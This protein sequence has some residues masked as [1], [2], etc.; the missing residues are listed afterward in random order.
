[1]P[2]R[3]MS[4]QLLW[5]KTASTTSSGLAAPDR[6]IAPR[7]RRTGRRGL[8]GIEPSSANFS[9]MGWDGLVGTGMAV[10]ADMGHAIQVCARRWHALV[11]GILLNEPLRGSKVAAGC[12][13]PVGSIAIARRRARGIRSC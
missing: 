9:A 8:L 12:V 10:R 3:H 2:L 6:S 7:W 1:M 5:E 11:N 4:P 13:A